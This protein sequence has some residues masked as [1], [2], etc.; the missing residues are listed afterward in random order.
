MN[1]RDIEVFRAV[2]AAGGAGRAAELLG[3]SQPTV[4]RSVAHLERSVGFALF[5]RV[6]GKLAPTRD[7]QLFLE[8]ITRNIVGLD[9]LRHAAAR[10]REVGEGSLRVASLAAM[11]QNIVPRAVAVF[12]KKFPNVRVSLQIG[13]SSIV[14]DLAASGQVD[15]GLAAD[16]IDTMGV[17]SSVF[18]TPRAVCLVPKGHPL[19]GRTVI[20]PGDLHNERFVAL[21]PEDTARKRIDQILASVNVS[22][23]IV[24]ETPFSSSVAALVA[25]GAGI[26]LANPVALDRTLRAR[27]AMVPFEPAVYFRALLLRPPGAANSRLVQGFTAALIRAR[28]SFVL[29]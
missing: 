24:V 19:H 8:E 26:G 25:E 23:R 11:G 10:I 17:D 28:N 2:M 14:R 13:M 15:L 1:L 18:A 21:T 27:V 4:S 16:E 5:N 9:R 22:P 6:R 3:T 20:R 12:L 29:Q 7:G